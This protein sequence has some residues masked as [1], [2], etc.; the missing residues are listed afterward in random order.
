MRRYTIKI[1]SQNYIIDVQEITSERFEV[2][3]GDQRYEVE[4]SG[5]EEL[6][7]DEISPA[8]RPIRPGPSAMPAITAPPASIPS[9]SSVRVAAAPSDGSQTALISAP[10]PGQIVSIEVG[11][12]EPVQ[13]GQV[14]VVLEAM[15]MNNAIRAT[16]DGVIAEVLTSVG[17][18]VAFGE[19]LIRFAE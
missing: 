4:L 11:V 8:I 15:K 9:A 3:V 17:Q 14:L 6:S 1:G 2:V 10:M 13:R 19:A 12:N 18:H 5:E 16:R 7:G